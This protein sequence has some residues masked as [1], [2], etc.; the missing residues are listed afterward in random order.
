MKQ[1]FLCGRRHQAEVHHFDWNHSNNS[2][3]NLMLL[4]RRCHV[5]VHRG[6]WM[7]MSTM[8]LLAAEIRAGKVFNADS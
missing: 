8:V 7:P 1:C 5:E 4:I 2:P 6:G 3:D